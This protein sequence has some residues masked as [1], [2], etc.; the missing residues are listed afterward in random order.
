MA[1]VLATPRAGL[2]SAS[3]QGR[4]ALG[5]SAGARVRRLSDE[6]DL[7][8]LTSRGPSQAHLDGFDLHPNAWV[9]PP[10]RALLE[11]L[12]RYLLRPRSPRTASRP[13]GRAVVELKTVWRD[14]PSHFLFEPIESLEKLAALIPRPAVNLLLQHGV[15]ASRDSR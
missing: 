9:P 14:G 6:P 3:V 15:L 10:N 8:H 7:G 12:G 2:V 13:D 1:H 11:Q 4:V 5:P